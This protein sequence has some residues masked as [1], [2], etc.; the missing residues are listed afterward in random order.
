MGWGGYSYYTGL[1]TSK[2]SKRLGKGDDDADD[3]D[4]FDATTATGG[5]LPKHQ[6]HCFLQAV[7]VGPPAWLDRAL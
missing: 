2:A 7:I 3:D 6:A 5:R 4:V 1:S